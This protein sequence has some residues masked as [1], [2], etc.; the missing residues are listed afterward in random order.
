MFSNVPQKYVKTTGK[1]ER[2]LRVHYRHQIII[3]LKVWNSIM[4][5]GTSVRRKQYNL[6]ILTNRTYAE[7]NKHFTIPNDK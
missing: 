3:I 5:V 4:L 6:Q 1:F 7:T 2:A